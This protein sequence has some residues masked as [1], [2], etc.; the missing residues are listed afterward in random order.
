MTYSDAKQLIDWISDPKNRKPRASFTDYE[1]HFLK[2]AKYLVARRK[3]LSARQ[4]QVLNSIYRRVA[5]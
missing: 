3:D 4:G 1:V 2:G 5:V